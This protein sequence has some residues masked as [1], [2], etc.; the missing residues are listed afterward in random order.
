MNIQAIAPVGFTREQAP[1][2]VQPKRENRD[3]AVTVQDL[4]ESEDRIKAHNEAMIAL[5]NQMWANIML[6][7]VKKNESQKSDNSKS[8]NNKT[9]K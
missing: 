3:R 1:N 5:Q 6:T 9:D 7:A 8:D 2:R 4:Y